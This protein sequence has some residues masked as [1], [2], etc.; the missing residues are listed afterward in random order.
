LSKLR[1]ALARERLG[2]QA[3]HARLSAL[4]LPDQ[5]AAGFTVYPFDVHATELRS[6]R[7]VNV[8][9]RAAPG[10]QGTLAEVLSPGDPVVMAPLGRPG[11]GE[12]GRV[13]GVDS[14]TLELRVDDLPTGSGPWAVSRRLDLHVHDLQD[15]ALHHA[16][17]LSSPLANLLLGIE[18]P[19][20]PDPYPHAAFSS[21]DPAQREA[22]ELVLGATEIGLLH[23]PPGTGKTETLCAILRA[24]VDLGERPWALADSNAAVDHLALRADA[25]GLDVVRLGV[26][27]RI[28]SEVQPLSLEWRILHGARAEVIRRLT[29]ESHRVDGPDGIALRDA[30]R[31]EWS[32]AKREIL[33]SAQVL[34]LT[35]GTLHTRGA[36]LPSPRTAVVDEAS[37]VSEPALW[38]LASRVK[39]IFLAGDPAQLGPVSVAREPLLERSILARLVGEG[40]CFPM[41]CQQYR[42]NDPLLALCNPTY[43]GRL[44]SAPSV[45]A[46][47]STPAA[48]WI[49]TAGMGHDEAR[50]A[51]GSLYNDGE[52]E[53]LAGVLG[54]LRGEG[55]DDR[56]IALVTPYRAQL[57]RIRARFPGVAAGTVNAFQGREHDV[58]VGSF[59]R[60]NADG[61]LGFVADP[62]RLNVAVTRARHRF[63]GIGDSAT[64]CASADFR[65]LV[66]TIAEGGGYR[67][68]WELL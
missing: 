61:D 16:E 8:I 21:L 64:L 42:F 67:S 46:P 5:A 63:V 49:D 20:R 26:G 29:R 6:R 9:L 44:R 59:V 31:E 30:I 60:S 41:L 17:R 32:Q 55:V 53:L 40:F 51:L 35:L 54:R 25:A 11:V 47:R 48:E 66:D 22:A 58:I 10:A 15:Q 24:L 7:R 50:D 14:S 27:A 56:E 36:D 13:E 68:G 62:R 1:A 39:R 23:G 65:R 33:E 45:A 43:G 18:R 28:A 2:R 34:A 3:E 52:L 37:Q 38:L 12:A 4:S 57:A 19:Y